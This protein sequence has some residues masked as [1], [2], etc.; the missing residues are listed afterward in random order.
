M[1]NG[2]DMDDPFDSR[3]PAEATLRESERESRV[4]L[5]NIPGLVALLSATSSSST[6]RY[7]STSARRSRSSGNGGRTTPFI[8][9][10][11]LTSS[12]PSRARS[13]PVLPTTSHSGSAGRMA[14]IA[15]STSSGMG[16]GLSLS[17]S[18]VRGITAVSGQSRTT[19]R[20]SP[21]RFPF[22]A[23]Q[24]TSRTRHP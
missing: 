8:L 9:T 24:R 11:C 17:R 13:R 5:D 18:I 15:G 1:K 21:S 3:R 12:R 14:S 7:W 2:S 22:P 23:I 6:A 20:A 4:I 19:G 16:I 10:I